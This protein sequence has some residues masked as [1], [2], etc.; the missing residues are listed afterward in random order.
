MR[1][2]GRSKE[3]AHTAAIHMSLTPSPDLRASA[4]VRAQEKGEETL[5][6]QCS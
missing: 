4:M 2:M 3:K 1:A 5:S 6:L